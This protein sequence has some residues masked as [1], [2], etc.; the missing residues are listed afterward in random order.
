MPVRVWPWS[1]RSDVNESAMPI[2]EL[3]LV[4]ANTDYIELQ[5]CWM[6][7]Y[8]PRRFFAMH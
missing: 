8:R 1:A 3:G 2:G 7:T 6:H 4:L 5:R